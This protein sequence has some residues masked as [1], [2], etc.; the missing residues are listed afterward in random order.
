MSAPTLPADDFAREIGDI[1]C[2]A[3]RRMPQFYPLASF[4]ASN[5]L[6]GFAHE[7][8]ERATE[9]A[10]TLL[11][12]RGYLPLEAYRRRILAGELEAGALRA[13]FAAAQPT[14]RLSL[15]GHRFDAVD[16]LWTMFM[17]DAYGEAA[18]A[19]PDLLDAASA[20]LACQR[21][22]AT[23]AEQ[24]WD[25]SA[26]TLLEWLDAV[27]GEHLA[28]RAN[29]IIM[30]VLQQTAFAQSD[31][32]AAA[33][34]VYYPA[35]C[36]R[37]GHERLLE[38]ATRASGLE[39]AYLLPS[40]AVQAVASSLARLELEPYQREPYL[41]RQLASARGWA[42]YFVHAHPADPSPALVDLLAMR[43]VV[44]DLLLLEF[45]ARHGL[46]AEPAAVREA[47]GRMP[48]AAAP[49]TARALATVAAGLGLDGARV[50]AV[51]PAELEAFEQ[52]CAHCTEDWLAARCLEAA[53]T[54]YRDGLLAWL[55]GPRPVADGSR[56]AA[57]LLFCI[58]V[59][60]GPLRSLIERE[61]G[62]ETL[63]YAGFFGLPLSYREASGEV[64]A[65]C[66]ILL[67][68][69]YAV[70]DT[71]E[72]SAGV[73]G[74]ILNGLLKQHPFATFGLVEASGLTSLWQLLRDGFARSAVT[75]PTAAPRLELDPGSPEAFDEDAQFAVA[76][77]LFELTGLATPTA[78]LVVLCGHGSTTTNNPYAAALTCGA[79]GGHDGAPNARVMAAIL[80]R[81]AV[82]ARL[83]AAG[84]EVSGDTWFVAALHDTCTD[85][86]AVLDR[87]RVPA[88]HASD[89][90]ELEAVLDRAGADNRARRARDLGVDPRRLERRA[91]DFAEVRPEWGLA[92]NAAFI[93][94]PRS[95]TRGLELDGRCFLHSYD[96]DADADGSRLATIVC[97]PVVVAYMINTQYYF[98]T[99]D[100]DTWGS[101]NKVTQNVVGG[102]AV[103]QGDCGDL[104]TGLPLQ[105][106][107][108]EHGAPF[109]E[110]LRLQVVIDAPL[111]RVQQVLDEH[112]DVRRL[113]DNEWLALTV[114]DACGGPSRHY[115]GQGAWSAVAADAAPAWAD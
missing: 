66:P 92:G 115:L 60:S 93:V 32:A 51:T 40:D 112:P 90:A 56:P 30:P 2:A 99:V 35:L 36:E 7:P 102:R 110:P 39:T 19:R 76:R 55:E 13:R 103:M 53:E 82:R 106:V 9:S 54:Q 108:D 88:T 89:L 52:F 46:R 113:F 79:C 15:A 111:A 10:R 4:V 14:A 50:A 83:A 87:E 101:G 3:A 68:P 49:A 84:I 42:A 44:E 6:Q 17:G 34:S 25:P 75:A 27:T 45:A 107:M 64:R 109:H 85:R 114:L 26:A 61:P 31:G 74:E 24:C 29:E 11:G 78:R 33:Q 41:V 95:R 16:V 91:R 97:A 70:S 65:Q 80:N 57:Q 86:V 12:G 94:A 67:E 5:P 48:Q 47:Y 18:G 38:A 20:T 22:E 37:L 62:Y 105:S 23:A 1:A 43:L 72:R 81:P 71:G 69:R 73:S 59:R 58:D 104:L 96:P 63:G 100:N 98:S 28:Q 21:P 77:D 8:F